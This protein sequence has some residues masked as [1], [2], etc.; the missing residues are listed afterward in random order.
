MLSIHALYSRS[1]FTLS[2]HALYSP[3]LLTLSTHPLS[4]P[5]LSTLSAASPRRSR[6]MRF[7]TRTTMTSTRRIV[8]A[9]AREAAIKRGGESPPRSPIVRW[10]CAAGIPSS[11]ARGSRCR[12]N[13]ARCSSLATRCS[14]ST[15]SRGWTRA[16]RS[17]R[18]VHCARGASGSPPCGSGKG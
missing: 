3:S 15:A 13:Q 10:R 16:R 7:T 4:S 14:T 12:R 5:S 18:A 1:L 9:S 6:S 17:T 8:T 2:I 11:R